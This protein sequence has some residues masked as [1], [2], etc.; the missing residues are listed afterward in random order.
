[1]PAKDSLCGTGIFFSPFVLK[2]L[3]LGNLEL[4]LTGLT[5]SN[6]KYTTQKMF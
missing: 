2:T 5:N 1:M 6:R 3:W 4:L